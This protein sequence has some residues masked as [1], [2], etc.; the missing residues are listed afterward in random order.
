MSW[1]PFDLLRPLFE[2]LICLLTWAAGLL[3][4]LLVGMVNL[5]VA[6]LMFLLGPLLGLLP[7]VDLSQYEPPAYLAWANWIFP[8]D[9]FVIALGVVVLVLVAWHVISVGLR[10]LK[11]V[12]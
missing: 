6:A 5:L 9:Q 3:V 12:E 11:V 2:F 10:W 1:G 4:A 8:L 7:D